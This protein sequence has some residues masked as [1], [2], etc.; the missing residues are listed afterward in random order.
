MP[1]IGFIKAGTLDDTTWLDPENACLLRQRGELGSNTR[2][3]QKIRE[4][5]Q[6]VVSP[7]NGRRK[8]LRLPRSPAFVPS[9]DLHR[10]RMTLAV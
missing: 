6:V 7:A 2:R 8:D 4:G 9:A 1:E 3:H 5:T 10:S